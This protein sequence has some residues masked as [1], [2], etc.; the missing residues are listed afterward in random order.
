MAALSIGIPSTSFAAHA[1]TPRTRRCPSTSIPKIYCVQWDPNGLFKSPPQT[2]HIA[3]LEIKRR[4][5]KD[6]EAREAFERQMR[7]ERDRRRVLREA[8]VVPDTDAEMIEYFLDTEAQEIEFE[9]A[10]MRPSSVFR[11]LKKYQKDFSSWCGEC[12]REKKER[13]ELSVSATK[14]IKQEDTDLGTTPLVIGGQPKRQ[15]SLSQRPPV[16]LLR[17]A[18]QRLN[19]AFFSHLQFEIGQLRFAAANTQETEDRLIELEALQKALLEGTEGYDKMQSELIKAK[20]SLI[21]I[22]TSKDI[23]ATLLEMIEQN[24]INR[25]LLTLLDENIATAHQDNQANFHIIQ[26]ANFWEASLEFP[27]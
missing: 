2:G 8:R 3:R 14:Q 22:F 10:R 13:Q 21:K 16:W 23:K 15:E 1:S 20:K 6:A 25:A 11:E 19:E 4:L 18:K 24:E 5:E 12:L 17:E 27:D 9:I 7:E 26:S